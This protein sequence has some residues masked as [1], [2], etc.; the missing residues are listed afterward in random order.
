ME[1]CAP[2]PEFVDK[3][4]TFPDSSMFDTEIV[5]WKDIP[6]S[7]HFSGSPIPSPSGIELLKQIS[8]IIEGQEGEYGAG[9]GLLYVFFLGKLAD[10]AFRSLPTLL[11]ATHIVSSFKPPETSWISTLDPCHQLLF[12]RL[13]DECDGRKLLRQIYDALTTSKCRSL[14][15]IGSLPPWVQKHHSFITEPRIMFFMPYD[16]MVHD[17]GCPEGCTRDTSFAVDVRGEPINIGDISESPCFACFQLDA[18]DEVF[19]ICN[20][21]YRD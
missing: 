11:E 8:S 3:M 1:D 18:T 4:S 10:T 7:L 6:Q 16:R 5:S 19:A 21:D 9:G 13:H 12:P 15:N 17:G 2:H 14:T 20:W